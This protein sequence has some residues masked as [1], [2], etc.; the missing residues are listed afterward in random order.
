[1]QNI[2]PVLIYEDGPAAIDFLETAFGFERFAVHDG[3][4]GAI[5]HAEL[6]FGSELVMLS[7]ATEETSSS[8][9]PGA[10]TRCTW[11]ST[12]PTG[13]TTARS[14]PAPRSCAG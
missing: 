2:Y 14:G 6:R 5:A 4:N 8:T 13:I 3:E 12:I 9:R 7:S 10:T 1:M 11:W